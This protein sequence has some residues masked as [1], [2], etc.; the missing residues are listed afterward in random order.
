MTEQ[1][2]EPQPSTPK[3]TPYFWVPLIW[4][5]PYKYDVVPYKTEDGFSAWCKLFS[6]YR[7]VPKTKAPDK[8]PKK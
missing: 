3:K 8:V 5:D 2:K 4:F 7:L 6:G 1:S